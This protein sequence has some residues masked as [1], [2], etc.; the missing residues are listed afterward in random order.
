M[1]FQRKNAFVDR[2]QQP[3]RLREEMA[4]SSAAGV[5]QFR[6]PTTT[7]GASR[8]SKASCVRFVATV[9]STQP[10]STASDYQQ[11]LA[12]LPNGIYQRLV[13]QRVGAPQID[14]FGREARTSLASS[15]AAAIAV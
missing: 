6:E 14:H 2:I 12:G 7:G 11:H 15:S 9:C 10:R 13:I 5:I 8:S 1:T 3:A 4:S